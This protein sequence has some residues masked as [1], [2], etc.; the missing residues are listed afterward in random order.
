MNILRRFSAKK[1][2]LAFEATGKWSAPGGSCWESH[3]KEQ[4]GE[5]QLVLAAWERMR[6][7]GLSDGA[8]PATLPGTTAAARRSRICLNSPRLAFIST[9]LPGSSISMAY[10]M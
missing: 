6:S 3:T 2:S 5:T 8:V 1:A 7:P 4:G 10:V 9:S